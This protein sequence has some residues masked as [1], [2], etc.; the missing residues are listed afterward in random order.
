MKHVDTKKEAD[1]ISDFIRRSFLREKYVRALVAV[2]GGIDSAISLTLTIK[3][4][5]VNHVYGVMLPYGRLNDEGTKDAK[6]LLQYLSIPLKNRIEID[7]Q[8]A[9]DAFAGWD[10]RMDELRKGNVMARMRMVALYDVSKKMGA[11]VVGTENRTEHLLGYYT[12]FGD[13]ASDVE[14]IRHLY[15]TQVYEL[16]EYLRLPEKILTKPPSAGLW[17]GQTDEKEFGFSYTIVDEI[18][19]LHF[20]RR[21]SQKAILG[22][23]YNRKVID[24]IWWWIEKGAF[25]DRMPIISRVFD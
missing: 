14:P 17:K 12:R 19:R 25:K 11:L 21:L 2:S 20:D 7:I 13:E 16:A 23:G 1:R 5:G 22:K 4:L 3:A 8:P 24:R 18:L 6:E 9:V 10:S 15:K